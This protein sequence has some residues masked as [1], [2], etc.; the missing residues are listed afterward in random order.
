MSDFA[1]QTPTN[2]VREQIADILRTGHHGIAETRVIDALLSLITEAETKARNKAID[3]VKLRGYGYDDG[4]GFVLTISFADLAA[5][6]ETHE[7]TP[8]RKYNHKNKG[9]GTTHFDGDD[10]DPLGHPKGFYS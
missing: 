4:T 6:K 3:D 8:M 5:L 1:P 10:C 9:V 2:S 7:E